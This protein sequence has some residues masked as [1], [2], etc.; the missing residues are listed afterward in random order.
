MLAP[1][2]LSPLVLRPKLAFVFVLAVVVALLATRSPAYPIGLAGVPGVIVG[3]LGRNPLPQGGV[4]LLLFAWTLGAIAFALGRREN[5]SPAMVLN[6]VLVLSV[7]LVVLMLARLG[8]SPADAYGTFKTKTF[9][10]ENVLYV[11]AGTLI[12]SRRKD[13]N[14][15][16]VLTLLVTTAGAAAL[17]REVATGSAPTLAGRYYLT[18]SYPVLIG[19]SAAV[20]LIAA[21][22]VLLTREAS[23]TRMLALVALPVLAV[24]L[25]AAGS[26]G[27]VLAL[28]SALLVLAL[29]LV[30]DRAMRRRLVVVAAAIAAAA[31]C[32][33]ALV[34]GQDVSRSLSV[35]VGGGGGAAG[36]FSSN[37]RLELWSAAWSAF[38][39]HP[40]GGLGT[41]GFA[42][43]A[44][45]L[46]PHNI[47][48]EAASEL[49]VLG[50]LLVVGVL[51]T[52]GTFVVRGLRSRVPH[53]R[54]DA[55]LVVGL[56]TAAVVNS[57]VS[58]DLRTNSPVWLSAGLAIGLALRPREE[59]ALEQEPAGAPAGA[60][61]PAYLD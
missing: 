40:L 54:R 2:L 35:F 33:V 55:V 25:M 51:V 21:I 19:R 38:R 36:G 59:P 5:V 23:R 27:P 14:L 61:E 4:S 6:P 29:V 16:V 32:V 44:S 42:S 7:G 46:Y 12:A 34:P 13:F 58:G 17:I 8:V 53:V 49:G 43:L 26:R 48:L 39:A 28:L 60:P 15:Y 56:F 11:L 1:V 20:G 30:G 31:V 37:G 45:E 47:V 9:V 18:E 57:L 10:A 52:G 50:L 24:S 41:G 3:L 22:F